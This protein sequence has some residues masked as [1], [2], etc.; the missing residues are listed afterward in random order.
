MRMSRRLLGFPCIFAL[1]LGCGPTPDRSSDTP[2]VGVE[3]RVESDAQAVAGE[4]DHD[5]EVE[6]ESLSPAVT[7]GGSQLVVVTSMPFDGTASSPSETGVVVVTRAGSERPLARIA[8]PFVSDVRVD[9]A[10]TM[11]TWLERPLGGV[12]HLHT[13]DVATGVHLRFAS[14]N[15]GWTT[16]R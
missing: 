6:V 4:L 12:S 7:L 1:F 5:G 9:D 8:C 10:G 16:T 14:D 2:L 11:V 13:F 15:P 3:T